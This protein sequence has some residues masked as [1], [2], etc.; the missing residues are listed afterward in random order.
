[1]VHRP[2]RR[3]LPPSKR[4]AIIV[5]GSSRTQFT[6]DEEISVQHLV[7][8]LGGF[9]KFLLVPQ[10][11]MV[12][13]PGF[14]MVRL[15]SRYFGSSSAHDRLLYKIN[16]YERFSDYNFLLFYHLDSLVFSYKLLDW[17]KGEFDYIGAPWIHCDDSP[18]VNKSRVGN[19]GLSLLRV[20]QAIIALRQRYCQEPYAY[21]CDLFNDLAPYWMVVLLRAVGSK[22]DPCG[23]LSRIVQEWDQSRDP[24]AY[25]RGNDQFWSDKASKYHHGFRVA[26]LEDGL[27]FAFEVSPKTC[28][29]LA[30]GTMPFGCHAWSRYDRE[31]WTSFLLGDGAPSDDDLFA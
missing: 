19:G 7:H 2:T 3:S 10:K 23:L 1:M 11:T 29:E 15:P 18:W 30:G 6:P 20:E 25:G 16:F 5:P 8:Y 21:G 9:D 31:F 26:S 24:T 4:V 13:V 12:K 17:C 14:T 28:L 22:F 27:R